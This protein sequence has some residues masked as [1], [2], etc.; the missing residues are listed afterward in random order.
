MVF[1]AG[2]IQV[3]GVIDRREAQLLIECGVEYLGF[4][5]RLPV[6][7][8]DLS[9]AE[10][11]AL[12]GALPAGVAAVAITYLDRAAEVIDF[13]RQLGVGIV[14]LHG[15]IAAQELATIKAQWPQLQIIKSLVVR[16]GDSAAELARLQ[17]EVAQSSPW[18]DAYITDTFD[19]AS[20]ASGAT[21]R[22]HDWSIDRQLCEIAPKPVILAGG[23][24]ADNVYE[25][26]LAVR[27]SGVDVHTGIE[28]SDGRK[29]EVLTRRFVTRAQAAFARLREE[30]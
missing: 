14:Q 13:C 20:G 23:L 25:A 21:G 15:P 8:E 19:P 2:V 4:P 3:A 22:I 9:E 17:A 24:D 18:V 7:A 5:L 28:G 27:P 29:D 26:I 16:G 6:N 30:A 1:E 10:A 12:I 11:A